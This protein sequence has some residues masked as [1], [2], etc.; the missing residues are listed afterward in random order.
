MNFTCSMQDYFTFTTQ[1]VSCFSTLRIDKRL[2]FY[3][4]Y[5]DLLGNEVRLLATK[6]PNLI[7]YNL[8]HVKTNSFVIKEEMGFED[9]EVK[10]LILKK[11]RL[12]M[13]GKHF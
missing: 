12:W 7:T 13:I 5:F 4:D 8:Q 11:P 6:Q 1:V 2:G 3:Q 10:Q 9:N